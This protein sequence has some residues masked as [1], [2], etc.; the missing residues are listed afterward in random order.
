M[1]KDNPTSAEAQRD[2]V[3]SLFKLGQVTRDRVLLREALQ[4][5]RSLEHTGRL[6]PRDHGLLDA[7][8]QAIDS[9]P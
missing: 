4:I 1:A 2:V 5:A 8:T 6:A 7:I 3:V 9:I